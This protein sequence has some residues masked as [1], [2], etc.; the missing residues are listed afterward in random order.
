MIC[1]FNSRTLKYFGKKRTLSFRL[2]EGGLIIQNPLRDLKV[3]RSPQ[4][5][6]LIEFCI[7]LSAQ[8]Q[9]WQIKLR[10]LLPAHMQEQRAKNL[11]AS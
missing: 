7:G 2:I 6:T 4:G 1:I 11:H 9:T 5:A 10:L 3:T 8:S